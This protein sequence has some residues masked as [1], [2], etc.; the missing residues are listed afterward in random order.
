MIEIPS[1]CPVCDSKLERIKDQLFCR[2]SDC[3]ATAQK[4]IL[5]YAKKRKIL[6]LAEKSIEKLGLT[7]IVQIYELKEEELKSAL[8]AN[9]TKIYKEIQKS[10]T[11]TLDELIGSLSIPLVGRT[12]AKKLKGTTIEDI[13]FKGLPDKARANFAS[14]CCSTEFEELAE[15]PFIITQQ[16]VQPIG[17][18][19]KVLVI[20]GKFDGYTQATLK[21]Y[22]EGLGYAVAS[23]VTKKTTLLLADKPGS[24]KFKKA[25][26][27]GINIIS[28]VEEL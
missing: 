13:D 25:T 8:G 10:L 5:N 14:W 23:S 19:N 4:K 22:A 2:N 24:T 17:T 11:A 16:A 28:A 15:I 18:S 1:E 9:G 6:G 27:I 26:S 12:T 3:G 7:K 20:T 21:A